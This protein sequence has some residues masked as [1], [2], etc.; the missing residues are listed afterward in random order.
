M[1]SVQ[2]PAS[3]GIGNP[4]IFGGYAAKKSVERDWIAGLLKAEV[5]RTM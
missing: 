4:T 1:W 5:R 3:I 2:E